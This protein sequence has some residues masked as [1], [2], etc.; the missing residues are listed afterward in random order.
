MHY[1]LGQ[2]LLHPGVC[3]KNRRHRPALLGKNAIS[4]G[5]RIHDLTDMTV[6]EARDLRLS[7]H[8]A[9]FRGVANDVST[10]VAKRDSGKQSVT[11]F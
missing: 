3:K 7:L 8:I 4:H 10:L 5:L 2:E 1:S 6:R 9:S 11:A